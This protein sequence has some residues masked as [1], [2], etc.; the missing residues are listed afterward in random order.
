MTEIVRDWRDSAACRGTDPELH[1]PVGGTGVALL[2]IEDAKDVCR[3]CPSMQACGDWA[4]EHPDWTSAGVW[5]GMSEDER[6]RELRRR[7]R[8]RAAAQAGGVS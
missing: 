7:S 3:R 6:R 5:G 8:Q 4:L 1:F 2:Q